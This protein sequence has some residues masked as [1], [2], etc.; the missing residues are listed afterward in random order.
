MTLSGSK[1]E[2]F[3]VEGAEIENVVV[4]KVISL[5]QHPDSDHYWIC[6][7]IVGGEADELIVTGA[8]NLTVGDYV[9][10]ALPG[11]VVINRKDHKL[12]KI[13]KGKLRGVES[14]GMLCS[15]DELGLTQNAFPYATTE[16][17]FILGDDCDKTHG[18][19]IHK[20]IG[21]DDT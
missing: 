20:A 6:S 3:K 1:V 14:N 15:I 11:A 8:Q 19:E 18:M 13:K 12:E 9:P 4:G 16:G 2:E 10:V 5:T 7:I 21:Y 17:T